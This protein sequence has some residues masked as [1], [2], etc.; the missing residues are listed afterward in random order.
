M[1]SAAA[2]C[3]RIKLLLKEKQFNAPTVGDNTIQLIAVCAPLLLY[4][5]S[6]SLIKEKPHNSLRVQLFVL[7]LQNKVNVILPTVGA[8]WLNALITNVWAAFSSGF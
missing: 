6:T 2:C 4:P 7:F 3:R 1:P 5:I 8:L